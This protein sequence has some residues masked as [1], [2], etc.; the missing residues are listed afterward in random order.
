MKIK[1]ISYSSHF[2]RAF[3]KL[4]KNLK[5]EVLEREI[6]FRANCFD[7]KL[8]THKLSGHLKEFWSFSIT[9]SYRIMFAI[10]SDGVVS[11]I[12]VDDHAI[13]S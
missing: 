7:P 10:E 13:Y 2:K 3:K 9:G 8:K 4:P 6:S 11:F 12:D 1:Q 5:E